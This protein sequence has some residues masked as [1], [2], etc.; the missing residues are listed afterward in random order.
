MT[1]DTLP[2]AAPTV[3][4]AAVSPFFSFQAGAPVSLTFQSPSWGSK[5]LT[6]VSPYPLTQGGYYTVV[7]AGQP[8]SSGNQG[9]Q[10]QIYFENYL[11]ENVGQGQVLF[12]HASPAAFFV[13]QAT[14]VFGSFTPTPQTIGGAAPPYS[15]S[16]PLG[17]ATFAASLEKNSAAGSV[18]SS[19][20]AASG[21]GGIGFYVSTTPAPA[22]PSP[23]ITPS[24]GANP[25]PTP[26]PE[27]T[28][29]PAY[30]SVGAGNLGAL[31]DPTNA[32]PIANSWTFSIYVIDAPPGKE[33]P[34]QLV[35]VI[36]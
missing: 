5:T 12:H 20:V 17:S 4:Y 18:I 11:A 24:W 36:D 34:F 7:V 1:V 13:G 19:T 32:F 15:I 30:S 10:C 2:S 25:A 28:V 16:A 21:A 35:G 31:P 8:S 33:P 22:T 27:A 23:T 3:N 29:L 26:T 14:L 6:C 9:L